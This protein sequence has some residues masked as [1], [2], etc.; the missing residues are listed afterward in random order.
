[1]SGG[2]RAQDRAL[3]MAMP[4]Y[5]DTAA[6]VGDRTGQAICLPLATVLTRAAAE[7]GSLASALLRHERDIG[8]ALSRIEGDGL[9]SLQEVD[10]T[11][12]GVEGLGRF[13]AAL[14][15]Q[16]DAAVTCAAS[17]AARSLPMK[18]QAMRL[19]AGLPGDEPPADPPADPPELW[20]A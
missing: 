4:E 16:I 10:A 9:Q 14:A 19:V 5:P 1:M 2:R 3:P 8:Q 17:D 12:Q 20:G 7:A 6:P 15:R 13:L 18:A 11:R